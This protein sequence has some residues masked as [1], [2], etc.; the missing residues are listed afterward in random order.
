MVKSEYGNLMGRVQINNP[1]DKSLK[2]PRVGVI[3]LDSKDRVIGG[4]YAY[5]ELVPPSGKVL[6]GMTLIASGKIA[7]CDAYAGPGV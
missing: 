1:T 7:R 4:G 5:P 3:C 6:P 2:S